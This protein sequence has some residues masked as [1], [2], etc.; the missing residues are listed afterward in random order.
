MKSR[1]FFFPI[2]SLLFTSQLYAKNLEAHVHGSVHLD[3]A[4]EKNELL[5]MLKSPSESFLG[6]EHKAKTKE[7]ISKLNS[8]KTQWSKELINF[9]GPNVLKDC[10]ISKSNWV[11]KFSGK[12]HSSIE[13]ESYISC[14]KPLR[15]RTLEVSLKKQFKNI[16]KIHLQLIRDDGSVVSNKQTKETFKIKL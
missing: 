16:Q 13:A 9:I 1:L 10:K 3:I 2:L 6:F 5:I 8:V 15:G 7:E 14:S 11:Q 12:N 4:S